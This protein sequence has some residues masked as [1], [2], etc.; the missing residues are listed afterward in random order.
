MSKQIKYGVIDITRFLEANSLNNFLYEQIR[1][2]VFNVTYLNSGFLSVAHNGLKYDNSDHGVNDNASNYVLDV[3]GSSYFHNYCKINN[4]LDVIKNLTVNGKTSINNLNS[5]TVNTSAINTSIIYTYNIDISNALTVYGITKIFNDTTFYKN[6]NIA[7]LNVSQ[8][9]NVS[10][11]TYIVG[12][13]RVDNN[14]SFYNN[15]NL[16]NNFYVGG[17]TILL[18]KLNVS[19]NVSIFGDTYIDSKLFVNENVNVSGNLNVSK[20][21]EIK[22][23]LDVLKTLIVYDNTSIIGNIDINNNASINGKLN[24]GNNTQIGGNTQIKGNLNTDGIITTLNKVRIGTNNDP[25]AAAYN[26]AILNVKNIAYIEKL[27]VDE[28]IIS[29]LFRSKV[30]VEYDGPT[31]RNDIDVTSL[32]VS[33]II[34]TAGTVFRSPVFFGRGTTN[35]LIF[36][37]SNAIPIE[38]NTYGN[39]MFGIFKEF[40][41]SN[42]FFDLNATTN[43]TEGG[44]GITYAGPV[45]FV[46]SNMSIDG[47]LNITGNIYSYSDKTIKDNITKLENC[48]NKLNNITGYSFTRKDLENISTVHIGLLAQEVEEMFPEIVNNTN[49][50]KSI[51]YNSMIAVIIESIKELK[52]EINQ[53]KL[54]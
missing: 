35:D 19:K 31:E 54:K 24:V 10:G 52:K 5:S 7:K 32:R 27:Y 2:N 41:D 4:N 20:N 49:S 3:N 42:A 25:D 17:D 33:N 43:S 12:S 18:G 29:N 1:S 37:A 51:N 14:V 46:T 45:K 50:I 8:D 44:T 53:I 16:S 40:S 26:S 23:N 30:L 28:L 6:A 11:N 22:G 47:N 39:F 48:L 15:L 38:F 9:L 36:N 34:N 13:L 21:T